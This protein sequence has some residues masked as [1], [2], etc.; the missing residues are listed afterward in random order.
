[1]LLS[2]LFAVD[3]HGVSDKRLYNKI[4]RVRAEKKRMV[5]C[6]LTE[7]RERWLRD[8]F[9]VVP[10]YGGEQK[11]RVR[12]LGS[13]RE[14]GVSADGNV[15]ENDGGHDGHEKREKD[16]DIREVESV[17]DGGERENADGHDDLA[18]SEKEP[19]RVSNNTDVRKNVE[20]KNRSEKDERE[21]M[22]V[23]RET[24]SVERMSERKRESAYFPGCLQ[25]I[26]VVILP[27]LPR[28]SVYPGSDVTLEE[29]NSR[30]EFLNGLLQAETFIRDNWWFWEHR[31][32]NHPRYIKDGVHLTPEGLVAWIAIMD[33]RRH[34][35]VADSAIDSS[36]P[37]ED[38]IA[39]VGIGC[40]FANGANGVYKFWNNV[41]RGLDCTTSI[42][43]DRL[44]ESFFLFPGE[45]RPGK[46]YNVCGGYLTENPELFDR[47]FFKISPDEANHM[48]PQIRL[49]LE[50]V[51]ETLQD[52]GICAQSVRGSNTG[53]Y[54]GVT[55]TEYTILVSLPNDNINSYTNTGTNSCMISN[56]ISYEYDFHGPSL[57]VNT[58]CSSSMYSILLA[59][60]GLRK[61]QCDMAVAGGVNLSLGPLTSVGFCQGDVV[62]HDGKSKTFDKS[63]DGFSRGE[64]VGAIVLKPLQRAIEDEDRIYAVIRGGALSND[65]RTSGIARPNYDAQVKLLEKAYDDARVNPADV[66]LLE[67]HGTGTR[68]GDTIEANAIGEVMGLKRSPDQYPLYVSSVKT[69]YGHTEAAAGIAGVIKLALCL[70]HEQIPKQVHFVSW[71]DNVDYVNLNIR[72]P[73][74]LTAWPEGAKR[75]VGCSSFGFGGANAHVVME[76]YEKR[77][78]SYRGRVTENPAILFLSAA[79]KDALRSYLRDWENFLTEV[80]RDDEVLYKNALYTAGVRSTHLEHRMCIIATSPRDAKKQIQQKLSQ[81]ADATTAITEGRARDG[82]LSV[83]RL[84]F[85]YSGM[86]SQWW[87]MARRLMV[88]DSVFSDVIKNIDKILTKCGTKWSLMHMLTSEDDQ[89]KM[90][91]TVV[92]GDFNFR[93]VDWELLRTTKEGEQFLEIVQENLWTQHV[94]TPT[95]GDS[96]LDL[97]LTSEPSMIEDLQ[98]VDKLGS[99]DH[100]II[101]FNMICSVQL[102]ATCY[103]RNYNK[104]DYS[105]MRNRLNSIKWEEEFTGCNTQQAW[106]KLHDELNNLVEKYVPMKRK[107]NRT[108]AKWMTRA[109]IRAIRKKR[110]AWTKYKVSG[111]KKD[112]QY[113]KSCEKVAKKKIREAKFNF[114]KKI[115]DDIKQNPKSFYS[116]M[117]TKRKVKDTVGPL[118]YENGD[119][120]PPDIAQPCLCAVQIGLTEFFRSRGITPDAIVGHSVGEVA[121]AHAAGYLT[122][123]EA[124]RLIYTRGCQLKKTSGKGTM[125]A[126]LHD[127]TEIEERLKNSTPGNEIDVAAINGPR[128]IVLSGNAKALDAFTEDLREEGIRCIKLKVNNAFHSFQ[129]EEVRKPFLAKVKYLNST[130]GR[131]NLMNAPKVPFVS[132]VTTKYLDQNDVSSGSYW[133]KNIRSPVRFMAAIEKLLLDGYN[134]FLEI[135]PHPV[136]SSSIKDTVRS[137]AS[138]SNVVVSGTLQRPADTNTHAN[139]MLNLLRSISRLHVEGYPIEH[140]HLFQ[141]LPYEVVSLPTYPWQHVLCSGIT[142]KAE[143]TFLFPVK[144]H[145]LLGKRLLVSHLSNGTSPNVWRS[146]YSQVSQPWLRDHKLQGAVIVPAA[147]YVETML[148]ATRE[149][150]PDIDLITLKDVKFEKFIFAPDQQPIEISLETGMKKAFFTLRSF[151]HTANTWNL[152]SLA[153][154]DVSSDACNSIQPL[155]EVSKFVRLS[156]DTIKKKYPHKVDHAEF[157]DKL[158]ENGFQLGEAFR[159]IDNI[160]FNHDYMEAVVHIS[161]PKAILLDRKHFSFHPALF[162]CIFQAFGGSEIFRQKE[163]ALRENMAMGVP[164]QVPHGVEKMHVMGRAPAK[165]IMHISM[166]DVDGVIYGDAVLADAATKQVF[167]R[168]HNMT[169][170]TVNNEPVEKVQLWSREW[171]PIVGSSVEESTESTTQHST[172]EVK[173]GISGSVLIVKD[174]LG[175]HI[176]LIKRLE[177]EKITVFD[178]WN[179]DDL[180][181]D[182]GDLLQTLDDLNHVIILSALD[183]QQYDNIDFIGKDQ[184]LD[185]QQVSA[186]GPVSLYRV[187]TSQFT[188]TKPRCWIITRGANFVIEG[189]QIQ[190]LMAPTSSLVLT[191]MHEDPEFNVITVDLPSS[192]D[193]KEAGLWLS[194]FVKAPTFAENNIAL[195]RKQGDHDHN[196]KTG[197]AFDVHAQRVEVRSMSSFTFPVKPS[198]CRINLSKTMSKKRLVVEQTEKPRY[199]AHDSEILVNVSA[200]CVQQLEHDP[201]KCGYLFAGEASQSNASN[202][203]RQNATVIGFRTGEYLPFAISARASEVI[204]VPTNITPVRAVNIVK[205]Y[206]SCFLALQNAL[207]STAKSTAIVCIGSE[208]DHVGLAAIKMAVENGAKVYVYSSSDRV[209]SEE[210]RFLTDENIVQVSDDNLDVHVS[211]LSADVLVLS[212]ESPVG[213]RTLIALAGK[214]HRFG[215]IIQIGEHTSSAVKTTLVP[216]NS[217]FVVCDNHLGQLNGF[218][219]AICTLLRLFDTPESCNPHMQST[220]MSSPISTLSQVSA[221]I[222]NITVHIDKST[223]PASLEFESATFTANPE[224]SYL[225]TGASK[226]FG[227]SIVEWLASCGARHIYVMS[228]NAPPDE[229]SRRFK[230]LQDTGVQITHMA[231]DI[232]SPHDVE[233]ALLTIKEDRDYQLEGIFHSATAYRD[234]YLH[235]L[236]R[237][238]WDIVMMS[239]GYGALL[240]H[241]LT[242]KLNLP[243][244]YFVLV[245]SVAEMIGNRGQ[246]NYSAANRFLSSL[247][248]MRRNLGLP[249]TA[250]LP[251]VIDSEGFAAREGLIEEWENL[252]LASISPSEI[253]NVLEGI[254]S[255]DHTVVG[256]AGFFDTLQYARALHVLTSCHFSDPG[257]SF[258]IMKSLLPPEANTQHMESDSQRQIKQKNP[259]E[260]KSLI[261]TTLA[262]SLS[263]TLGYS[264]EISPET[265]LMSLGLDSHLSSDLSNFIHDQFGVTLSAITFLN[266][267]L[268][269]KRL[270]EIIYARIMSDEASGE[271][272]TTISPTR[273]PGDGFWLDKYENLDTPSAQLI[274]FPSVGEGPTM[275]STWRYQLAGRNIQMIT[276]Q[277]PGWERREQEKPLQD[278]EEIVTKLAEEILPTLIRGRFVFFGHSIGGLIAFELTHYLKENYNLSPAH[279]FVSSWFSPTLEYPRPEDLKQNGHTYRK[280]QR[281]V[282]SHADS[283]RPPTANGSNFKF[284]FFEPSTLSTIRRKNGLIPSIE[285]AI[286]MC[287]KYRHVHK[288]KLHCSLT[289]LGGKDDDFISPNL[290]DDWK[291]EIH[292]SARFQKILLPG[293]HMYI[294]SASKSVLKEIMVVMKKS[295]IGSQSRQRRPLSRFWQQ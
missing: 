137:S 220:C 159:G 68:V 198:R 27:V 290:L 97:V 191:I 216:S 150:Y 173:T 56:R 95:R 145:P 46:M 152:N 252:G 192:Q 201:I 94:M 128:Q 183:V 235:N 126:I 175:L 160:S 136:L 170:E 32:L 239:K 211:S 16:R 124:V 107:T 93:E 242:T 208:H 263:N 139:D 273:G 79:S 45:K 48:D 215:T 206:L 276:V 282:N 249:A 229:T 181:R 228:R 81:D 13:E 44:D 127:V 199:D 122:L 179:S 64:G 83:Q 168:V 149:M 187:L 117:R 264:G 284:S 71:N 101:E 75:L 274:C 197:F 293:K 77:Q 172:K 218:E 135:G 119:I 50:V 123:E 61:G 10:G 69:N 189:D 158:W 80:I 118:K 141:D 55:A 278:L 98:V 37:I 155:Q 164:F 33:A 275:F 100:R 161:V 76:G 42:P 96:I 19:E 271:E 162:D 165:M 146:K 140:I 224:A 82:H 156:P 280:I 246:G 251:G 7:E 288:D 34:L 234:A 125:M 28:T 255:S 120:I 254:L 115:A 91:E 23:H 262:A 180:E 287:K 15:R 84:V 25:P 240:L 257:G 182:F 178:P 267:T 1:M 58:A 283:S 222:E 21:K 106:T 200:F 3:L 66:T 272:E 70:Q 142:Q 2:G 110:K 260:S 185:A 221:S 259:D 5:D 188:G 151:N 154:V 147:A 292:P 20:M 209:T 214:L 269:F 148:A 133:W 108:K 60:D 176:E 113:Y 38:K 103:T 6:K 63:A 78:Y 129:Q 114:E 231:V 238:T 250:L 204:H 86:G 213:R 12:V 225:V 138:N 277:I 104:S 31:G 291:K 59:C 74:E 85:V 49:L 226:G 90:E 247:C 265:T 186:L 219:D 130:S 223:I 261:M 243:L 266:E 171:L 207:K 109:T 17:S 268:T 244:K 54:M 253:F 281:I 73:T 47:Q 72:V 14:E 203:Y 258:S 88:D 99:S 132:T 279:L 24:Q 134:C 157:Y 102:E 245:S 67:A 26:A 62:S 295:D 177:A 285:A 144:N 9:A 89:K 196:T 87:G 41:V 241:Q 11:M 65:G 143:K 289:V 190:P 184:F 4:M 195:R 202:G 227:L 217:Y 210:T 18:K 205:E 233:T 36:M 232:G 286:L 29:F 121:A 212:G 8:V 111:S 22:R 30:V 194:Q 39:I 52:A 193:Y 167:A 153:E 116:Y 294:R 174:K 236:S 53:V 35:N 131:H 248:T 43:P 166:F 230:V 57:T 40:R 169:F 163:K 256:V 51:W 105:A 270:A 112:H 237:E 92:M